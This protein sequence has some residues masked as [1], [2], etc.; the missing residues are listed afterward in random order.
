MLLDPQY[1]ESLPTSVAALNKLPPSQHILQ[2]F[3]QANESPE[4]GLATVALLWW[5]KANPAGTDPQ[6]LDRVACAATLGEKED[7][8]AVYVKLT[9][10]EIEQARTLREA[11]DLTLQAAANFIRP[12]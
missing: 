9:Q 11:A 10:L 12:E 4:W 8:R 5:A 2:L 6:W 3:K 7:P 1:Y